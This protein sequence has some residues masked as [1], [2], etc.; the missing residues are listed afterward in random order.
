VRELAKL[1]FLIQTEPYKFEAMDTLINMIRAAKRAGHVILGI[2]FFGSGVFS[3]QK[4]I[5][6]GGGVR[7]LTER[8]QTEISEAGIPIIGCRTWLQTD[9]MWEENRIAN[10]KDESLDVL[11]DIASEADKLIVFGPGV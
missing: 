2:F 8:L 5:D 9:G 6:P 7:N 11:T 10:A 3:L 1:A 4:R